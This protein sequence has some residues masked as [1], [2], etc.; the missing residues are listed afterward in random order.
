MLHFKVKRD[1]KEVTENASGNDYL[2]LEHYLHQSI[3]FRLADGEVNNNEGLKE[4]HDIST[5]ITSIIK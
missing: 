2:I 4:A 3:K 1:L 5:I